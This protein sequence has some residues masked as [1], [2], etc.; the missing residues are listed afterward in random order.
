MPA[1]VNLDLTTSTYDAA[2]QLQRSENNAGLTTYTY[3]ANGNQRSIETPSSDI[4]TH[5]WTYENQL[6]SLEN[7]L[8]EITT[9][10]YSPVNRTADEYQVM[11]ETDEGITYYLYDNNNILQEY[12]TSTQ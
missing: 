8:G 4:T 1:C 5:T 9:Y 12:E 7:P 6:R 2:N 3:D 11:R 10:A